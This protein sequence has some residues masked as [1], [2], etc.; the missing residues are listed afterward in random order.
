MSII[1][2]NLNI[3]CTYTIIDVTIYSGRLNAVTVA[4]N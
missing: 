3:N 1:V 2:I 4:V